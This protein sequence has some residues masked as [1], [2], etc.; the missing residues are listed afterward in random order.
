LWTV[1]STQEYSPD[2]LRAFGQDSANGDSSTIRALAARSPVSALVWIAAGAGVAM[3]VSIMGLEKEVY[4]LAALMAGYGIASIV[5]IQLA[6]NGRD[7]NML[8]HIVGDFSG[9]PDIMKKL[10]LAQFFSWSA[11]FIMWIYTTPVVAQYVFGSSD[12]VSAAY[13]EGGNWG[14]SRSCCT[15]PFAKARRAHW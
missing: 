9:M 14:G 2:E 7:N 6:K 4:L 1:F 3:L 5:A 8:S 13:N 12:P 11:L 15:I 10:A